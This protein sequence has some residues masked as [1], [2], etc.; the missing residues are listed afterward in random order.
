MNTN[1]FSLLRSTLVSLNR[2][3]DRTT[4]NPNAGAEAIALAEEIVRGVFYEETNDNTY[5]PWINTHIIA[6]SSDVS[7]F[8]SSGPLAMGYQNQFFRKVA[9]PAM[10]ADACLRTMENPHRKAA[11]L[12]MLDKLPASSIRTAMIK[13]VN[14][15]HIVIA[16][17]EATNVQQG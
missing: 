12:S 4:N 14:D 15:T 9:C 5:Y 2:V 3:M 7:M 8:L 13:W 1:P 11:A 10:V 6:W 17:T 16:K